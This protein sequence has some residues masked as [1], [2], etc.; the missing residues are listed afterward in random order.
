MLEESLHFSTWCSA[1]VQV[2]SRQPQDSFD[3]ILPPDNSSGN[4]S[5][6]ICLPPGRNSDCFKHKP[7]CCQ[8]CHSDSSVR[9]GWQA[10][11]NTLSHCQ[12]WTPRDPAIS[13]QTSSQNSLSMH[14]I[15]SYSAFNTYLVIA[16]CSSLHRYH[17]FSLHLLQLSA[18]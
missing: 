13:L 8:I 6:N 1:V 14:L 11:S 15:S 9:E 17:T 16:F 7:I 2:S 5:S 4:C 12:A 18:F 10:E 3:Q